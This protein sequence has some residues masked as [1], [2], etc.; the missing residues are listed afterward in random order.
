[1]VAKPDDA[2]PEN[3]K[4]EEAKSSWAKL[5]ASRDEAA[6]K[7]A[8]LEAEL[9]AIKQKF[10][11]EGYEK[12]RKENEELTQ[13]L[14]RLNVELHPKFKETFD[15]PLQEAV[16]W[17]KKYV[18]PKV[19]GEVEKWLK[20]P[21]S[22]ERDAAI[23]QITDSLPVHKQALFV[24]YVGDAA[25]AL[26]RKAEALKNEQ[27][28]TTQFN[29]QEKAAAEQ[30]RVQAEAQGRAVFNAVLKNKFGD[31]PLFTGDKAA[32]RIK[33]A[34]NVLFGINKPEHLAETALYAEYGREAEPLLRAAHD[35]LARLT[36]L[37]DKQ[38]SK[39]GGKSGAETTAA[40]PKT[41]WDAVREAQQA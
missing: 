29:E 16:T 19:H 11:P 15:K 3:A 36:A 40:K 14:R 6:A 20:Q 27:Q 41:M 8:A 13:I 34:E 37:L 1:M 23:A 32:E 26:D 24:R 9:L 38:T 4:S 25:V 33:S 28:F 30:A 7:S 31:N 2:P 5:K 17:A 35:E 18:D 39:A 10:D 22:P 21:D 12:A